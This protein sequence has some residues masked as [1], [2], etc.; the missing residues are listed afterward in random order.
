GQNLVIIEAMKMENEIKADG[1][2]IVK[3]ILVHKGDTISEGQT[4]VEIGG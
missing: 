1:P 2:G 4:L 3:R